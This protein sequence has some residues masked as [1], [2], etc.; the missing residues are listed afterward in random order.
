[1]NLCSPTIW[2][3]FL[4]PTLALTW[5]L[6][7]AAGACGLRLP[8][9]KSGVGLGLLS[10]GM[11]LILAGGLPTARY[12]AGVIDHWSLP[13]IALLVS[14][15]ARRFLGVELLRPEDRKAAWYFGAL[16]G[17]ALYPLA[18]GLGPIDP[19]GLG[20]RFG[21]LFAGMALLS[22]V[23][24]WWGNRF[25]IVLVLAIAAWLFRLPESGNYWD[26]LLDP[27]YFIVSLVALVSNGLSPRRP[28]PVGNP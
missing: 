21:P 14:G 26:C 15:L 10:L 23:L 5:L 4:A 7:A 25:G 16:A 22:S 24:L 28:H 6:A 18:L 8:G 20:W 1:M 3:S 9:W 11:M 2:V 12:L 27:V 19:Y 13:L 17:V